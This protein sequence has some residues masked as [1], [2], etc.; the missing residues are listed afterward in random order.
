MLCFF[1]KQETGEE[2]EKN[3]E[4]QRRRTEEEETEDLEDNKDL[5]KGEKKFDT[6]NPHKN[7]HASML[8]TLNP[9]NP[10]RIVING[11]TRVPL[12]TP[13]PPPQHHA[14]YPPRVPHHVSSHP[15]PRPSSQPPP[16]LSQPRYIP[17]ITP[18]PQVI[19]FF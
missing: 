19:H 17:T 2:R 3:R 5:E 7:Y 18:T 13:P 1:C 16:P 12:T 4:E 10:L 14:H 6:K 8:R 11:N 15:P 9:T